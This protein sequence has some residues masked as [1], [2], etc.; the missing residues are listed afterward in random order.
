MKRTIVT[1]V[2]SLSVGCS[3]TNW[4]VPVHEGTMHGEPIK[5]HVCIDLPK[6]QREA[7]HKAVAAWDH[8][9]HQWMHL[10]AEDVK[11]G[12]Q[13]GGCSYYVHE[14]APIDDGEIDFTGARASQ[15]GGVD[16]SMIKGHYEGDTAGIVLHEVG[17]LLGAQHL[18]GT[19]MN[20]SWF[21][22]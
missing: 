13:R 8:A 12:V 21:K 20:P 10:I 3:S 15:V 18:P 4:T 1:I 16:I 14:V 19:L 7:A 9:L 17:H 22:Y 6:E 2:V 5:A 11:I